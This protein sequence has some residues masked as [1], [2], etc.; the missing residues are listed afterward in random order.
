MDPEKMD[1]LEAFRSQRSQS[2]FW[3]PTWYFIWRDSVAMLQHVQVA[4]TCKSRNPFS[5]HF[6]LSPTKCLMRFWCVYY[7]LPWASGLFQKT[8]GW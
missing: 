4:H 3:G 7:S 1:V 8:V 5:R 6:F 2:P